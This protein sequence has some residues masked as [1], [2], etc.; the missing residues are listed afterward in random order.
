M[1]K[2][3]HCDCQH[4]SGGLPKLKHDYYISKLFPF[5]KR[6]NQKEVEAEWML[7]LHVH[8][9]KMTVLCMLYSAA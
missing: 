1:N 2:T 5:R 3:L 6:K 9:S 4:E 8:D 7:G